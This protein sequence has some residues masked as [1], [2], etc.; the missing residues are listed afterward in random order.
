MFDEM[1][2]PASMAWRE[3]ALDWFMRCVDDAATACIPVIDVSGEIVASAVGTLEIGVPNP[4]S[5]TGRGVRLANV[6]TLPDHRGRGY[7]TELIGDVIGWAHGVAV[8]RIDL[9]AT[10]EG[11]RIYERL[12]FTLA[13]APRMKRM[14]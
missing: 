14:L 6:I 1:G 11:Q 10:P 4:L 8:D 7:A 9:S 3:H 12:G 13:S 2:S 5:P